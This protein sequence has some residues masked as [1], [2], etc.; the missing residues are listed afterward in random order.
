VNIE[1]KE[2]ESGFELPE[3]SENDITLER[4][5]SMLINTPNVFMSR[6]EI[7]EPSNF[8]HIYSL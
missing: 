1:E 6:K 7:V 5:P 3:V 8:V 2:R 4:K